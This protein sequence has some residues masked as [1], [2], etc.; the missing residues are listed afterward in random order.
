MTL[1]PHPNDPNE[2]LIFGSLGCDSDISVA[3]WI[4]WLEIVK[5]LEANGNL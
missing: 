5:S 1:I 3:V 4:S 2:H